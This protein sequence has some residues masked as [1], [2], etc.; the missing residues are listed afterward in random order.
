MHKAW[1]KIAMK[2]WD[3]TTILRVEKINSGAYNIRY[4]VLY[5]NSKNIFVFIAW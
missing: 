1:L 2:S 4:L 5:S 3:P